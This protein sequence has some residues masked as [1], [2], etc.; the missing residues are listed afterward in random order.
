[1]REIQSA[2][3]RFSMWMTDWS[4]IFTR[5]ITQQDVDLVRLLGDALSMTLMVAVAALATLIYGLC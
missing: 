1:M 2:Q 5:W 3:G 4:K